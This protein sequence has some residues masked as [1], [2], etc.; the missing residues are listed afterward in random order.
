LVGHHNSA[1][2]TTSLWQAYIAEF[3]LKSM[4]GREEVSFSIKQVIAICFPSS[5]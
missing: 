4:G 3:P 5:L 2:I 1:N